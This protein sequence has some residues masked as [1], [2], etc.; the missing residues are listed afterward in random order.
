MIRIHFA[1]TCWKNKNKKVNYNFIFD[2]DQNVHFS[3]MNV[4]RVE[5]DY[6]IAKKNKNG[7]KCHVS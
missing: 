3:L 4:F 5:I 7:E 1:Q 6:F 2:I